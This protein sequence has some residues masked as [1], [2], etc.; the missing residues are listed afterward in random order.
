MKKWNNF[1]FKRTN[2]NLSAGHKD[3]Q[4]IFNEVERITPIPFTGYEVLRSFKKQLQY[5][6]DDKSDIDPRV[7]TGKHQRGEA[8]DVYIDIKG[9]TWDVKH[10]SFL[11]GVIITVSRYL[12][13]RGEVEHVIRWGHD[14]NENGNLDDQSFKDGPHFEIVKPKL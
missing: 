3:L 1:I 12:Y 4:T 2:K 9:K 5:F 11:A 10:L 7:K 14:W 8:I 13:E 6:I